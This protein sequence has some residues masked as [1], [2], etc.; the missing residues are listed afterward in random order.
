M[1]SALTSKFEVA[2]GLLRSPTP[3]DGWIDV[4]ATSLAHLSRLH[5]GEKGHQVQILAHGCPHSLIPSSQL[6]TRHGLG[7]LGLDFI[8][9]QQFRCS[10]RAGR[11]ADMNWYRGWGINSD[12]VYL[13]ICRC[14]HPVLMKTQWQKGLDLP[15]SLPAS[16][17]QKP[18]I[19]TTGFGHSCAVSSSSGCPS[20]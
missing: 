7:L 17:I 16:A 1:L 3:T 4:I 19:K 18:D 11:S 6:M 8:P 12:L 14:S 20:H 13:L 10:S 5:Q 2:G 9:S 15:F